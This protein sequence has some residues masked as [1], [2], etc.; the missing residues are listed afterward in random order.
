M[1]KKI[2]FLII[3]IVIA[4]ITNISVFASQE[5]GRSLD[6]IVQDI[7]QETQADNISN[8]PI[9]QVS[10]ILLE[11]LGDVV[12]DELISNSWHHERMDEMLGGEGSFEL[13]QYHRDLG[14][15]Y[16]LLGGDLNNFRTR[17]NYFGFHHSMMMSYFPAQWNSYYNR[18]G[19]Y[20]YLGITII[21]VLLVVIILIL[22]KKHYISPK[23][24]EKNL[25]L[26]LL[27]VRLA[28]GEITLSDYKDIIN[29]INS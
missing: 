16:I 14:K 20:W 26:S 23:Y 7:L 13:A 5:H 11:E 1:N 6:M 22:N 27:K 19:N 15:Q 17:Q 25:A 21:L 28:R 10:P 29:T 12:M 9:S 24:Q 3:L 8:I 18:L 4:I 2:K